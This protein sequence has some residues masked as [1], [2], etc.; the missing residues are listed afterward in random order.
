LALAQSAD[1]G[2]AS[3]TAVAYPTGVSETSRRRMSPR[4]RG[5]RNGCGCGSGCGSFL[6]VLL[7]GGALSIGN[8]VFGIGVTVQIPFTSSNLTAAGTIGTKA[9]AVET[10]P[11]HV[12]QRLAGN[13]N[14]INH[15]TT[16]TI[17]PA[18]GI[19]IMVIGEQP[20]APP[21]DIY[22]ALR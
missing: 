8:L 3:Q 4:F 19:G 11:E 14:F 20:G 5:R 17:G 21:F 15:S 16:L 6:L 9:R 7:L 10:L 22:L 12:R 18:E 13:E 2:F 1:A